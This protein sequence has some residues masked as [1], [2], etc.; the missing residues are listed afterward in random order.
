MTYA[1]LMVNLELGRSNS[2]I[3]Q[4]A[5]DLAERFHARVVGIATGQPAVQVYDAGYVSGD[6]VEEDLKRV[7]R[8]IQAAQTEFH[9]T[10]H[11]RNSGIEWRS[12]T[13]FS[14]LADYVSRQA[15]CADVIL[16]GVGSGGTNDGS[17]RMD[18]GDLVMQAGRPVLAVP[19]GAGSLNLEQIVVCWKDTREARRAVSDALPLLRQAAHVDVVEVV[20]EDDMEASRARL[21][22]VVAWLTLHGVP[23]VC[24]SVRAD[25]D[26][27]ARLDTFI[28]DRDADL[29]VAGAY[30]HT[31]L[32]EWVMGGVS[33]DLLVHSD[34][35]SFLAH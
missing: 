3:L 29:V 34:R 20:D 12:R 23:A 1:T 5:G 11:G 24:F 15:R 27:K 6:L 28:T 2:G 19:K 30:G 14:P 9:A 31:R 22:D 13:T 21:S 18:A 4:I 25:G 32:H 17:R 7:D 33:R 10:L 26:E 8:D 16:T 35:C